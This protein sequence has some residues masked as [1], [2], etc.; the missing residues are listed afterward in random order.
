MP[1]PTPP[2]R[3][4]GLYDVPGFSATCSAAARASWFA[5]PVTKFSKVRSVF[6]RE[7]SYTILAASAFTACA[8][9]VVAGAGA[10]AAG[11]AAALI[12]GAPPEGE[13][14]DGCG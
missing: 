13:A 5:L 11:T 12:G 1:K 2:Y 14:P 10:G 6:R 8:A 7:R 9:T 4:S 3:N